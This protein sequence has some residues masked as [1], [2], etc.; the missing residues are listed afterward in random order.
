MELY[1]IMSVLGLFLAFWLNLHYILRR[2]W[3][4]YELF[5]IYSRIK[6]MNR[7]QKKSVQ[8]IN[9]F[10]S[11]SSEGR[12]NR[13]KLLKLLW[14]A[15]KYHLLKYG[16]MI[17]KDYYVA[18]PHGPI[19]SMTK[20]LSHAAGLN[21]YSL[22]YISSERYHVTSV[23]Q[24]DT[25]F[26]SESDIEVMD[27]VWEKFSDFDRFELRDLTHLY[28]EWKR[29]EKDI[30]NPVK[31]SSYDMVI[32]DFFNLPE[33]SKKNCADFFNIPENELEESKETVR[34]KQKFE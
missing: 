18:M 16:R 32:E 10:A 24:A 13:L 25:R 4:R 22:A 14:L 6:T 7:G 12:I 15:D 28:P 21:K 19:A 29:F 5:L 11:K 9:Y 23:S 20:D 2:I 3:R 8:A 30:D 1:K 17:L 34:L 33:Q 27:L 31:P 26:F